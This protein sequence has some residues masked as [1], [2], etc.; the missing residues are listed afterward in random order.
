M[1]PTL[2]TNIICRSRS[3][4]DALSTCFVDDLGQGSIYGVWAVVAQARSDQCGLNA[5][6]LLVETNVNSVAENKK[7][8]AQ[9]LY[10]HGPC[11]LIK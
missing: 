9:D 4:F 7:A 6:M 3:V 1:Y 11:Q 5:I 8:C 2:Q 10:D